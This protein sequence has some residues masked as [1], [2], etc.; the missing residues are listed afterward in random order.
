MASKTLDIKSIKVDQSDFNHLK[1]FTNRRV[2]Q[3][4]TMSYTQNYKDTTIS[5]KLITIKMFFRFIE[6]ETKWIN[7]LNK[8]K[9]KIK[10]EKNYIKLVPV[11]DVNKLLDY[12]YENFNQSTT[13]L[14]I[15]S[16]Y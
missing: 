2:S 16:N 15:F 14:C 8:Y 9:I 7:P 4:S 5:R 12:M 11:K 3:E 10:K 1:G 6:E 13:S